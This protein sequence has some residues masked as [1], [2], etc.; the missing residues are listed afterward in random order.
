M[1]SDLQMFGGDWTEQ[2]LRILREYLRAYNTALSRQRFTRV[3]VDA[4]AG[5]G[6]RARRPRELDA[7]SLFAEVL[8]EEPQGFLKGSAKLAL[9]VSPSFDRYVFVES[10]AEK[11]SQLEQLLAA[12]P[13]K[14]GQV[15]I[16]HGEANEFVRS[17]CRREDWHDVRA[18]L[19]LDPFAT[20][21]EW[22]T[23]ETVAGTRA[24]DVWILF[25]LMAVDRL[26]ASDP[27]KACRKRLNVIFG[28]P[29]W[30]GR[31]YRTENAEDIFGQPLDVVQRACDF[32]RIADF[33]LERLR[34]V[35]PGVAPT[36]RIL[37]NS[38]NTP[39]FQFFFAAANPKGARIA[40]R[41]ASHLLERM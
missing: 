12:H 35:F 9:E 32:A 15:E 40:V 38:R 10:D 29:E 33:F 36:P 24:I 11:V 34:S 13:G 23:L 20:Q 18:V 1:G 31:F 28:T 39:L 17:F 25:P 26:L 14:A 22:E 8:E 4:F 37:R 7:P 27:A 3:Y 16:V 21:V 2:K 5:T 30:F 19:F 6:Y 41:I